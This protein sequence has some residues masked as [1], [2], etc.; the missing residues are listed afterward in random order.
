MIGFWC[1]NSVRTQPTI[2]LRTQEPITFPN[3]ISRAYI[4]IAFVLVQW[5]RGNNRRAYKTAVWR[6]CRRS[7]KILFRWR[8]WVEQRLFYFITLFLNF[9]KNLFFFFNTMIDHC[10]H[11]IA[12][13]Y[14]PSI[15]NLRTKNW[16]TEKLFFWFVLRN[17]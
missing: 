7:F 13:H 17:E 10:F 11:I 6:Q 16:V 4:L 9:V 14:H 5:F 12:Q 15:T 8:F 3:K 1:R 2:Q